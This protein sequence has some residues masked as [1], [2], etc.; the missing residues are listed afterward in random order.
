MPATTT[1]PKPDL[2]QLM[3]QLVDS[4]SMIPYRI[5]SRP[6]AEQV[7]HLAPIHQE[8]SARLFATLPTNNFAIATSHSD[9]VQS[10]NECENFVQALQKDVYDF[11]ELICLHTVHV[12]VN[13][14]S[15]P[16]ARAAALDSARRPLLKS[17]QQITKTLPPLSHANLVVQPLPVVQSQARDWSR[18]ACETIATQLLMSLHV[19][20]EMDVIGIIEWPSD[21]TCT[22]H[23]YRHVV[24]QDR[25]QSKTTERN[26]T[27][28]NDDMTRQLTVE[29]WQQMK[30]RNTFSI[31]RHEHH[32]MDAEVHDPDKTHAPIPQDHQQ[33][34]NRIPTWIRKHVRV[35]EGKLIREEVVTA[36]VRK[37]SFQSKPIR[38]SV[39]EETLPAIRPTLEFDPAILLGH[40]VLTGWTQREIEKEKHRRSQLPET[41]PAPP[42]VDPRREA[43]HNY[44]ALAPYA[45]AGVIGSGIMMLWSRL[46]P[47]MMVPMSLLIAVGSIIATGFCFNHYSRW[48]RGMADSILVLAG[49]S[50]IAL[51]LL[52]ALCLFCGLLYGKTLLIP[53]AIV[54]GLAARPV[55]RVAMERD[56]E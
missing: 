42:V 28:T 7:N 21:T 1:E 51:W 34:L 48:K 15:N 5:E 47:S 40:Y 39:N 25:I 17:I 53:I 22:L 32:V 19:L 12:R 45:T 6:L 26:R 18:N 33:F 35:L 2:K 55:W 30:G 52:A 43:G 24:T 16:Q 37:E 27:K 14:K 56:R 29:Q 4:Y 49:T 36:V 20:V 54:M 9:M 10:M 11:A 8:L 50:A 3:P 31:E 23:Y 41:P 38:Q 13:A 46:Q 44:G